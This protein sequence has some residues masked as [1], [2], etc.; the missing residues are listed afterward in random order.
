MSCPCHTAT[1]TAADFAYIVPDAQCLDCA[2]KHL[3][4]A[5]ALSREGGYEDIN[6]W[7][8]IGELALAQRHTMKRWRALGLV[9]RAKRLRVQAGWQ[10]SDRDWKEIYA[11]FAQTTKK[12]DP[13]ND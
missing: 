9:I 2:E 12:E 4:E 8:I 1:A 7:A 11:I 13:K 3:S 5:L 10:L 6:R